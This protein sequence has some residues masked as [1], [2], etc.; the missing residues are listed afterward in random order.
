VV[1]NDDFKEYSAFIFRVCKFHKA[2]PT[3][4]GKEINHM[5]LPV[6]GLLGRV[7]PLW[8]EGEGPRGAPVVQIRGIVECLVKG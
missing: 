7:E 3:Q 6:S 8:R 1:P 5:G 2:H 4:G